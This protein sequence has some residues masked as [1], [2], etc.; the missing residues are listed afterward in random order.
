[1][2]NATWVCLR[3]VPAQLVS[4]WVRVSRFRFALYGVK[5]GRQIL[6]NTQTVPEQAMQ[7]RG[8]DM[9]S[10]PQ[11]SPFAPPEPRKHKLDTESRSA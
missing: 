4:L 7:R 10:C 6:R 1:M 11:E 2:L 5:V 9:E 3:L 8:R